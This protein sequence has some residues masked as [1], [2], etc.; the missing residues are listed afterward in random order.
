M[1]RALL[2][3][4]LL[5]APLGARAQAVASLVADNVTVE[6][7][8]L[9]ATGNVEVFHDGTR[10]SAAAITYDRSS[11]RLTIDG[12]IY[13]V[14]PRGDI[15]TATRAELD[16]QLENGIL[17]GARLVLDRQLQLAANRLYERLGFTETYIGRIWKRG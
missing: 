15:T 16:P 3:L 8:T 17:R 2:L 10:L 12:P 6:G 5:L 13:I 14:S 1:R 4:A 7:R 9:S 11:E